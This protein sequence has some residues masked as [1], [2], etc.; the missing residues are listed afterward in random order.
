MAASDNRF[1]FSPTK[2]IHECSMPDCYQQAHYDSEVSN[3][4]GSPDEHHLC[5]IHL[6]GSVVHIVS[7]TESF[8]RS[9]S[10][11]ISI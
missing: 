10:A 3:G 9:R 6:I 1:S 8:L 2:G 7:E 5:P 4:D 11:P